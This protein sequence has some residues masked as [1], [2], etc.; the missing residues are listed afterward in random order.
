MRGRKP[1]PTVL[2]DLHGS[3]EP[4]NP[5]EPIPEGNLTDAPSNC[6][7]H[8]NAE[9]RAAWEYAVEHSP[10][11]ML[12]R[13]DAPVLE[14][15]VTAHCLHRQA[16]AQLN[17]AR[18][19]LIRQGE[20]IIPS[21]WLSIVNKQAQIMTKIASELG[22]TPVSRPRILAGGIPAGAAENLSR[23]GNGRDAP[24]ES[25][26]SYLANAPRPTAIH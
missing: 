17:R 12:K 13:I 3:E 25:I 21:P 10:P 16:T 19:P 2:K 4:R 24:Q 15:W 20:Q 1:K 18:S 6:P 8:F 26:E 5:F 9:Q 14:A 11:G 7:E 23:P 22:F